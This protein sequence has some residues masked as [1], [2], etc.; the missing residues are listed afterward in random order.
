[1]ISA[2]AGRL[3]THLEKCSQSELQNIFPKDDIPE[4]L[5]P[6]NSSD[7][8]IPPEKRVCH[9]IIQPKL[10]DFTIQ[11]SPHQKEIL[12]N[13]IARLFYACNLPFNLA[14]NDVFKKSISMLRPGYT[15][16]A[17]KSLAGGLLDKIFNEVTTMTASALEGKDVTLVQDGWSDIHNSHVIAHCV[18]LREILF[19]EFS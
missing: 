19:S 10:N 8:T 15:L 1:M 7:S 6:F 17:R 4:I 16:P 14:E 12:A 3:I 13:Q 2:K 18:H 11:T 9:K 5:V